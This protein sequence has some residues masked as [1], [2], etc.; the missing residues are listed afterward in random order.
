MRE[1]FMNDWVVFYHPDE[2]YIGMLPR[3]PRDNASIVNLMIASETGY[4]V[5]SLNWIT[6]KLGSTARVGS[7]VQKAR[8]ENFRP[9]IVGT[10]HNLGKGP[11]YV[12]LPERKEF[13]GGVIN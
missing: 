3:G 10:L 2:K 6:V 5:G 13:E 8:D 7:I 4:P 1:H 9:V 12:K 11:E